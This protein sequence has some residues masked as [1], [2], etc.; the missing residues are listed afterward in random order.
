MMDRNFMTNQYLVLEPYGVNA[1]C[2]AFGTYIV[3][4]T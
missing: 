1:T 2:D 4:G 3:N